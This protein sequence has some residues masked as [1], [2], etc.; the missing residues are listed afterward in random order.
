MLRKENTICVD[1]IEGGD[2]NI[3]IEIMN[4]DVVKIEVKIDA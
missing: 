2:I 4:M 1:F 3:K